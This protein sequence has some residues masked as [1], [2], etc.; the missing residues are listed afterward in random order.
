MEAFKISIIV[1]MYNTAKYLRECLES[2][3]M[4]SLKDI[5]IILVNDGSIDDTLLI[6][7]E[8]AK[9]DKRFR[10]IDKKNTGYG[11]S[12]NR[13]IERAKGK[14]I[15]IVEPDDF[16]DGEMFGRLYALAV[17]NEVAIARGGYYL[18]SKDGTKATHSTCLKSEGGVLSPLEDYEVFYEPP[19]IWSAIYEKKF[20]K[21]NKIEFLDTPGASYQDAGFH[22]KTLA[23]AKRIAY[24]DEPL[25]YYRTD[26]PNSSVKSYKKT[27]AIVREFES[28]EEFIEGLDNKGLLMDY[29]QVAKFG[30]YHWNLMRLE[31]RDAKEFIKFAKEEFKKEERIGT[32]KKQYFPKKYWVSYRAMMSLPIVVYWILFNMKRRI[33]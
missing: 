3:R 29:C 2:L 24:I 26:N 21:K 4:Q 5:E 22:F 11:D 9:R 7:T 32:I 8:Y 12:V 1:P 19:A 23:C 15:G 13:G 31:E 18:F 33:R 14:Y 10:I 27:M 30:R 20:L 17:E 28:I 6:A 25:Y 16:C